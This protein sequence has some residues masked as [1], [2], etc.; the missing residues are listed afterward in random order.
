LIL[1]T[2][3]PG[4]V[5]ASYSSGKP[6]IGVGSGN[7]PV[8]VDETA[9]LSL[10]C[11]SIVTG[12]TFDNGMICAAEQSVV[13]VQ[14]VYDELKQKFIDRGVYFVY[15][16]NREKLANFM[17]KGN[18]INAE[19]VGKS[20]VE[21]A[22][23]AGLDM[24]TIPEGTVILGTEEEIFA[25]GEKY[26]FSHEKLSPIISM[27]KANDFNEAIDICEKLAKNGGIGH[28]GGLY[29][30]V[31]SQMAGERE[32]RY[33]ERV[34]VGRVLVNAPI[35]LAAIG[36]AFNFQ[37][38]PSFSLGVGTLAGSSVSNNLGPMHLIN[39][40]SVA[41][42]QKHIEWFNLPGRIFFN[43][44]CLEEGLRECGKVYATG[45]Q[46]QRVIIISGRM[47][48]KLGMY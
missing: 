39:T 3:G 43:R 48:Q 36:T 23:R 44:G 27:Y 20:A 1:S 12:K 26:P 6:A 29:T 17:R 19:V 31:D 8:L 21:I 22:L 30:D 24:N 5:K 38:D 7:A 2:G 46:D 40:V 9:D 37:I 32:M 16:D 13:V 47:N 25:I 45:E 34:P 41:E 15:G 11:G 42:R 10:A 18:K 14:E 28:T 4:V 35:S 33:V